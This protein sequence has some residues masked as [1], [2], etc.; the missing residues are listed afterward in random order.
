[1]NTVCSKN[2]KC[3]NVK[4]FHSDERGSFIQILYKMYKYLLKYLTMQNPHSTQNILKYINIENIFFYSSISFNK[5]YSMLYKAIFCIKLCECI[6]IH[7][8]YIKFK[9][10]KYTKEK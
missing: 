5:I 8:V 2:I 6:N 4:I 1:M 3:I 7:N 10:F 9:L